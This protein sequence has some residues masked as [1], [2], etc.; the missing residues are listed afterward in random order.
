ML[1]DA[2]V[3]VRSIS[4]CDLPAVG[5]FL[6]AQLNQRVSP[7]TWARALQPT[8][9]TDQQG[10]GYALWDGQRIVGVYAAFYA[11]PIGGDGAR[12]PIANL[13]AW[14]VAPGYRSDSLRLIRPFLGCG[15][16]LTDFSPSGPVP[17]INRRLGFTQLDTSGALVINRPT[18]IPR[19]VD[20]VD[21]LDEL[22]YVLPASVRPAFEDH[23]HSAATS[24]VGIVAAGRACW[25]AYRRVRRKRLPL[26]ASVLHVSEPEV[27][28]LAG[29]ALYSY[30]L[31][32]DGVP[33]TLLERRMVS[34]IPRGSI[35][36]D[37]RPKFV[38]GA[39]QDP[40]LLY[41]ELTQVP[42]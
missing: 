26:F 11:E 22:G 25:V 6:S 16:T 30:L 15:R 38:R 19:G 27:A 14:C 5:A 17:D 3:V 35:Q 31:R 40:T 13:A 34:T 29:D 8:W 4:T 1:T 39:D 20:L 9:T 42:W 37:Q 10:H 21:D 23:R 32:R 2:R 24:H 36:R 28:A 41:S 33:F 18:R 7:R 12:C